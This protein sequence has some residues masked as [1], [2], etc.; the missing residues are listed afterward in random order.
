M[1]T[2][3]FPRIAPDATIVCETDNQPYTGYRL[4][5]DGTCIH[6]RGDGTGTDEKGEDW[7]EVYKGNIDFDDYE[8][9]GW[10]KTRECLYA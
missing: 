7:H 2:T 6:L 3:F 5:Q 1:Y 9:L 8:F 10:V 4:L